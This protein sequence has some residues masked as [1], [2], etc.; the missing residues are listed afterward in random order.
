[1][2]DA[3]DL[4]TPGE[5]AAA[6]NSPRQVDGA[7]DAQLELWISAMSERIDDLCGPVVQRPFTE[8]VTG[9]GWSVILDAAH[10]ATVTS[11]VEYSNGVGTTVEADAVDLL[12][13]SGYVL[14]DL[15]GTTV[16]RRRSGGTPFRWVAGHRN[17]VV[18]GT[19]GRFPTTDDVSPKFKTA[20]GAI[21]RRFHSREASSW[22]TGGQPFESPAAPG[23]GF[24]RAVDPMVAE[25]LS[26]ELLGPVIA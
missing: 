8:A 26:R 11:V 17:I 15:A 5:A 2:V 19:A 18:A 1:M 20:A 16:L 12:N 3:L 25:L 4:L 7:I 21:L 9:G 24:F 13:P 22:S 23:S 14:E 10:V 6:I